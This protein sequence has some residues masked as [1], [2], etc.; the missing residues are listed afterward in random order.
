MV[1]YPMG[2]L[3]WRPCR[4]V[5]GS[6]LAI[7]GC[8][9]FF[10]QPAGA[11]T[12]PY[13]PSS[14]ITDI[15]FDWSSHDRQAPGSDN[16]P[17]TW[18]DDDNIYTAWGDG[19]GFGGTNSDGRVS[20]GVARVTGDGNNYKVK[21]VWGGKNPEN[22]AQFKGKSYGILSVKG[23]LYMWLA[24]ET[25]PIDGLENTR[26]A[27]STDHGATWQK[28]T[29]SFTFKEGLTIPTFLNFGKNYEGARDT[30]VYSYYINPTWGPGKTSGSG[31]VSGFNVHQPGE[32]FL[33][34]VPEGSIRDQGSYEF[35]AGLNGGKIPIWTQDLSQK[36]PVFQDTNGVGWNVAVS[37]NPEINRYILTTEHDRTDKGKLGMFEAPEPW[38]PWKTI[39]YEDKWGDGEIE[40]STF[41]WNFPTKWMNGNDFVLVFTGIKSNDSWNTIEGSFTVENSDTTPPDTPTGVQ[42][43]P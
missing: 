7:L 24:F 39:L 41:Y 22:P 8:T 9:L 14:V 4:V 28:E 33:S 38:G 18:A 30:Y 19:G 2:I 12:T 17:T 23:I 16:W 37:Y 31:A 10:L 20:L 13:P 21:N 36:Q 34:R 29:W 40:L 15:T 5:F 6:V 42:F 27:W 35:F 43:S 32:L 1:H 11:Q 3:D 25:Y 26:V